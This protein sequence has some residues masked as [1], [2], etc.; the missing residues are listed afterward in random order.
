MDS[1]DY[2]A[3]CYLPIFVFL[4]VVIVRSEI[5]IPSGNARASGIMITLFGTCA[6]F[7]VGC[8]IK[9]VM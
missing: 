6:L 5:T 1:L 8:I 7:V 4:G 3:A 9:L 2:V